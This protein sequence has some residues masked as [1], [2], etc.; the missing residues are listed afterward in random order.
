VYER[1]RLA[2]HG[3]FRDDFRVTGW[4]RLFRRFWIDEL[5]MLL[6]WVRGDLKF[7][8]VRPI[9]FQYASLYPQELLEYRKQFKPG[10]VPPMYADMPRTFDGIL[11]SEEQYLRAYER[12]PFA[13][14]CR[15]FVKAMYNILFRKAR[16]S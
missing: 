3:K 5:P 9:S 1:N 15:Y 11:K 4:G 13:T 6:N 7:V 12:H 14:D 16:S 10:L 8:G 2:E